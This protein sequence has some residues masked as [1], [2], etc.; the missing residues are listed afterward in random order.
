M[1][2]ALPPPRESGGRATPTGRFTP[3]GK[4]GASQEKRRLRRGAAAD[5]SFMTYLHLAYLGR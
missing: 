2:V 5:L 1:A 3:I 4:K